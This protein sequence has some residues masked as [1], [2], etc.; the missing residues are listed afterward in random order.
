VTSSP[1]DQVR[2]VEQMCRDLLERCGIPNAQLLR[3][4]DIVELANFVAAAIGVRRRRLSIHTTLDAADR[5]IVDRLYVAIDGI[6]YTGG[7]GEDHA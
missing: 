4:T 3:S 2:T 1:K 7:D 5:R 6:L